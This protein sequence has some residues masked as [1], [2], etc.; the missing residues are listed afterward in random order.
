MNP[1]TEKQLIYIRKIEYLLKIRFECETKGDAFLW[2]QEHTDAF[3]KEHKM[4]YHMGRYK[5]YKNT[6]GGESDE[7]GFH[8]VSQ[9]FSGDESDFY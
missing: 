7:R 5:I 3:H 9:N 6:Y 1:P 4:A 8:G 2:I